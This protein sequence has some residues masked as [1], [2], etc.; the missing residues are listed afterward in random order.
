MHRLPRLCCCTLQPVTVVTSGQCQA[1]THTHSRTSCQDDTYVCRTRTCTDST[2]LMCMSRSVATLIDER[3]YAC[4]L[5]LSAAKLQVEHHL[6]ECR[7]THRMLESDLLIIIVR[8]E[9]LLTTIHSRTTGSVVCAHC[10]ARS[11]ALSVEPPSFESLQMQQHC[12]A[13]TDSM[14]MLCDAQCGRSGRHLCPFSNAHSKH[15]LNFLLNFASAVHSLHLCASL[16]I[17]P[18]YTLHPFIYTISS[19]QITSVSACLSSDG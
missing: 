8:T 7:R 4:T 10:F 19:L 18:S 15:V 12:N 9:L 14:H 11:S 13:S 1:S 16:Y 3:P 5:V 17:H 6:F 2:T